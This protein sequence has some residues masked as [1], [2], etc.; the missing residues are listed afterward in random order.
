[1]AKVAQHI[2]L[3]F[4]WGILFAHSVVPHTHENSAERITIYP[5][6]QDFDI[7]LLDALSHI[8]HFSTG[9]DHLED[10]AKKSGVLLVVLAAQ[11]ELAIIPEI[12]HQPARYFLESITA[13]APPLVNGLRAPPFCQ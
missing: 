1:M 3:F 10:Y 4:A 5:G 13:H 7:G 9:E 12:V 11:L 6:E 8:F 2:L